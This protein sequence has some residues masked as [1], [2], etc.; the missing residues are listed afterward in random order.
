MELLKRTYY[1]E[2]PLK[3]TDPRKFST[4]VIPEWSQKLNVRLDKLFA[5]IEALK[6]VLVAK[7]TKDSDSRS[8]EQNPKK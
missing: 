6:D 5:A 2:S 7:L 3:E 8:G 4:A 1:S